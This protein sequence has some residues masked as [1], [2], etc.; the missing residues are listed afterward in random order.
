MQT[1]KQFSQGIYVAGCALM[2]MGSLGWM[3]LDNFK[4]QKKQLIR[5]YDN[6]IKILNDEINKLKMD[7]TKE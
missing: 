7:K 2:T 3:M 6:K 1:L 5:D 4:F